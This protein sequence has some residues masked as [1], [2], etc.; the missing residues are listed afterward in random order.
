MIFVYT[1]AV[2]SK[3]YSRCYFKHCVIIL[4]VS[5]IILMIVKQEEMIWL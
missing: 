3:M 4:I 1:F 2:Y 5:I